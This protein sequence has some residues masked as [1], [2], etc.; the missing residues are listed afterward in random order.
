[1]EAVDLLC[2]RNATRGNYQMMKSWAVFVRRAH[3]GTDPGCPLRGATSKLGGSIIFWSA[4]SMRAIL[5]V[6]L[7]VA[8]GVLLLSCGQNRKAVLDSALSSWVGQPRDALVRAWGPPNREEP[9]STGGSLLIYHSGERQSDA[10]EGETVAGMLQRCRTEIETDSYGK[11]VRW[12]HHG[13]C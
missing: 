11:V 4:W 3:V 7:A 2:S 6:S 8:I 12:Q 1:M 9:L 13:Q 5:P 10:P